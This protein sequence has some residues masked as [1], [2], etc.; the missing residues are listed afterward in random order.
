[1]NKKLF[2]YYIFFFDS[3]SVS[4]DLF[5][6][7]LINHFDEKN[8]AIAFKANLDFRLD[9]EESR[10]NLDLIESNFAGCLIRNHWLPYLND[11]F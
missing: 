2:L 8:V 6:L 9:L 7:F 4:G 1:M 5:W 10:T 3:A 11:W